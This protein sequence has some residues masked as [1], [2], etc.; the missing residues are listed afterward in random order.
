MRNNIRI[1]SRGVI[2][3][4]D[5]LL[6]IRYHD[7]DGEFYVCVGGGQNAG[8]RMHENL[9][10]ECREEIGCEVEIGEML[11]T[12]EVRFINDNNVPTHQIEHYF[13]CGLAEGERIREGEQPDRTADGYV[14]VTLNELKKL[15]VFPSRLAELIENGFSERY[16]CEL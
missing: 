12:R 4:G 5:K 6:L 8:E 10:R 11:F 16:I 14:L 13:S 3:V 2:F 15:R 7:N 9:R 1:A